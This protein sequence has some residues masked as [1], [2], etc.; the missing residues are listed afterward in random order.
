[1][2]SALWPISARNLCPWQQYT[3][4]LKLG[5]KTV[6]ALA[7]KKLISTLQAYKYLV[8]IHQKQLPGTVHA[9]FKMHLL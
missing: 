2:R 3:I 6:W 1:M 4:L 9:V 7:K 5:G 8:S